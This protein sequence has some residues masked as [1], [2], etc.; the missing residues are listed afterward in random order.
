MKK[1]APVAHDV[2][3]DAIRGLAAETVVV[4]HAAS[5]IF[6]TSH[7]NDFLGWTSHIAVL[8]FFILSGYVITGSLLREARLTGT[9]DYWD[10]AIR[11]IARIM[12]PYLFTILLVFV[13]FSVTEAGRALAVNYDVS[14]ASAARSLGFAFTSRDAIVLTPVWSLR[15]EVGLYIFAALA[16]ASFLSRGWRRASWLAVLLVLML[17][18]F[19]KLSFA[20]TAVITFGLGAFFATRF[21]EFGQRQATPVENVLARAG[22]FSYTIYLIHMPVIWVVAHAFQSSGALLAFCLAVAFANL[23]AWLAS[24]VVE[25]P[26]AYASILRKLSGRFVPREAK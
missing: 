8:I 24:L 13:F 23:F 3:L 19:W 22:G 14:F 5:V 7:V 9:I 25:R 15:L 26:A 10:F 11:R 17:L 4:G 20:V 2:L 16:M 21:G 12:P 18:Y 1:A 6:P